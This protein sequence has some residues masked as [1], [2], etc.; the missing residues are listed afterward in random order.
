LSDRGEGQEA[1]AA[2]LEQL[3]GFAMAAGAWESEVLP[4]RL[5]GY[6][7]QLL[8]ALCASGRFTWMR[9]AV[10][11][12]H[13]GTKNAPLRHTPIALVER[14]N[15]A[16]WRRLAPIPDG[17]L[18]TLSGAAAR[19][20]AWMM[21]NGACFFIDLV[22]ATGMLRTQVEAALGE[23]ASWG[24]VT[25]DNFAGLRALVT[26][27]GQRPRFSPRRGRRA[28]L[29]PFDAAG[30]W[31][32]LSH[33]DAGQP[34]ARDFEFVAHVFLRRYGVVFRKLLERESVVIPWRELLRVYWRLEARGEI[35]GGR[36]VAGVAGEQ[37][38]L[39]D[40][41]GALRK[42]RQREDDDMLIPVSAVDPL[43]LA[44]T[45]IPGERVNATLNNRLLLRNGVPVA[46]QTGD[47]LE[48]LHALDAALE[49]Q[50]RMLLTRKRR[51]ADFV[52][53]P[54]GKL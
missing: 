17:S 16:H 21:E 42:A 53:P 34:D 49:W 45:L 46:V 29:S 9:L 44:G 13:G 18:A 39:P 19:L 50:A 24:M 11:P 35:R 43:N 10:A 15:L 5:D 27:N 52:P 47:E 30:R 2:A 1:A 38:A 54:A 31:S 28:A 26:P 33:H 25:S 3:E 23:L 14:R 51:P 41:L 48:F 22:Q 4:A 12:D 37:F 7:P 40:A 8:D 36:F 20:R 6:S 32:L